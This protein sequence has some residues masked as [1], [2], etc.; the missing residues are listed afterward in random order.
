MPARPLIHRPTG[1]PRPPERPVLPAK[2][3]EFRD[4]VR[5]DR[6]NIDAAVEEQSQLFLEV[7]EEQVLAA[8][9][10]AEAKDKLARTDAQ[11]ARK[12]RLDA[13]KSKERITDSM[14]TAAIA[15]DVDHHR[16]AEIV[17]EAKRE[18]D[19]WMALRDAYDHRRSM[20]REL[21]NLYQSGFYGSVGAAGP[22]NAVREALATTARQALDD[23]R[24]SRQR[25]GE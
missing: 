13:D 23:Q 12:L 7:S 5:I 19:L 22:R 17:S 10:L 25:P 1:S 2:Y 16:G 20:L 9:R 11:I 14:V 3:L 21:V 8:S 4:R 6:N 24:R 18:A 15:L